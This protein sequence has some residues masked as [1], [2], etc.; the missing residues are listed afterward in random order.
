MFRPRRIE[1][2]ADWDD[3]DGVKIYAIS[4]TGL[5]VDRSAFTDELVE[6]KKRVSIDWRHTAAF[7]IFHDGAT[8]PYLTLG[9]WGNDN[10][11]FTRVAARESQAWVTDAARYSFCI[12]DLE[13]MWHERQQYI[14]TV[15]TAR[16]DLAAYRKRGYSGR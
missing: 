14:D 8:A 2:R 7:A 11:L 1:R 5:D 4:A 15:Y 16:P 12:W 9:W 13:V 6:M 10:E 3:S